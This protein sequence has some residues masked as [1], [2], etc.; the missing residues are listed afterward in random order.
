MR[1]HE[2]LVRK[3]ESNWTI[4]YDDDDDDSIYFKLNVKYSMQEL[5]YVFDFRK[6]NEHKLIKKDVL[7]LFY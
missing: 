2:N 4:F 3:M 5:I 7:E 6:Q 1:P